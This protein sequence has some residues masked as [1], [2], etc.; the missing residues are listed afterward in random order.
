MFDD[1]IRESYIMND[2]PLKEVS[3]AL[4][5]AAETEFTNITGMLGFLTD[6]AAALPDSSGDNHDSLIARM[7][8]KVK[9]F[10]TGILVWLAEKLHIID[11][12]INLM[13]KKMEKHDVGSISIMAPKNANQLDR[14]YTQ[15]IEKAGHEIKLFNLDAIFKMISGKSLVELARV[16]D[17]YLLG[18]VPVLAKYNDMPVEK[19]KEDIFGEPVMQ[20]KFNPRELAGQLKN[21]KKYKDEL[22]SYVSIYT[23]MLTFTRGKLI[24]PGQGD[25]FPK[26]MRGY[27]MFFN[28][29]ITLITGLIGE[30]MGVII[31]TLSKLNAK[32]KEKTKGDAAK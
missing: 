9:E 7:V 11:L 20:S 23:S 26:F 15:V 24:I 2:I 8:K 30:Y 32:M 10:I 12:R 27:T 17:K 5:E 1:V 3:Q 16:I 19:I 18:Y 28:R 31:Q 25:I 22:N 6:S 13:V 21:V 29:N 4:M 14:I